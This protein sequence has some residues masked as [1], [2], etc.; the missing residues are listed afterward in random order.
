MIL[1]FIEWLFEWDMDYSNM[2]VTVEVQ[3]SG[4]IVSKNS[5]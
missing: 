1:P 4:V 5:H 3:Y 2:R